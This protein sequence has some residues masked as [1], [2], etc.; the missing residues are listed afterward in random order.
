M[1][2]D[3]ELRKK[4]RVERLMMTRLQKEVWTNSRFMKNIDKQNYFK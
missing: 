2:N 4:A 3:E 1:I